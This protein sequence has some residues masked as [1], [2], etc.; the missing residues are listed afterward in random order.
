MK[1]IPSTEARRKKRRSLAVRIVDIVHLKSTIAGS[2]SRQNS[3]NLS[4]E[5]ED[6]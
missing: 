1:T 2:T 4:E 3:R 6:N 5:S